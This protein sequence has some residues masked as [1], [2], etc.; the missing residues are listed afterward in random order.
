[1]GAIVVLDEGI[2]FLDQ[3]LDAAEGSTA[4]RTLGD[5][6]EPAFDLIEPRR[7]RGRVVHVVMRTPGQPRPDPGMFVGGVIVYDQMNVEFL[8]HTPIQMAQK[9]Q[10]LLVAVP[11]L[12]FGEDRTGGDVEGRKQSCG[13]M[14]NVV[15][16]DSLDIAQAHGQYRLRTIRG[17][18]LTL[19]IDTEYESVV[20]RVQI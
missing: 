9:R 12:A 4:N 10:E 20:G 3:L 16:G 1:M 11:R 7:V 18:N 13:A 5:E 2:D 14:A 8:R 17:L 6:T 15:V 19:F